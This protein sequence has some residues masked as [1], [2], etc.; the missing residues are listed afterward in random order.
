MSDVFPGWYAKPSGVVRDRP[1]RGYWVIGVRI[2]DP[3]RYFNLLEIAEETIDYLGG[4]IVIRSPAVTVLSGSLPPRLL[5]VEFP[6]LDRA[7][8]AVDEAALKIGEG[9]FDG[10]A[11]FDMAIA[12]GYHDFG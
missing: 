4:R 8:E 6:S 2:V 10:V 11:E 5:V 1:K 3:V 12:E 7:R 9:L